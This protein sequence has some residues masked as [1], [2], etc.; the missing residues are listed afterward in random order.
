ML[1]PWDKYSVVSMKSAD[2]CCLDAV[3]QFIIQDMLYISRNIKIQTF[4]GN[5]AVIPVLKF[6]LYEL[7]CGQPLVSNCHN[8]LAVLYKIFTNIFC[9]KYSIPS[10]FIWFSSKLSYSNSQS[11]VIIAEKMFRPV[12]LP[13]SAK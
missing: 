11:N 5:V 7:S 6:F 9:G 8:Y 10:A 1:Y 2:Y 12:Y 4:V 13:P 3:L